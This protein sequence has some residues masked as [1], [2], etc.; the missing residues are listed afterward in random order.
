MCEDRDR[1]Q[2]KIAQN[3]LA[4]ESPIKSH[5]ASDANRLNFESSLLIE[6]PLGSGSSFAFCANHENNKLRN[7]A[8]AFF[9]T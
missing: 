9:A 3:G 4:I 5:E 1:Q 7:L 6:T 2:S 8:L